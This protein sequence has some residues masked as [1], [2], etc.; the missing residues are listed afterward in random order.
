V[1]EALR[2][3]DRAYALVW[4]ENK[5]EQAIGGLEP[6]FEWIVPDHPDGAVRHGAEAVIDFWRDWRDQ[7]AGLDVSWELEEVGADR[8][9]LTF[10]MAGRGSVSGAPAEMHAV[11]LWTFRDG[12][13]VRMLMAESAQVAMVRE[14]THRYN[15]E[16]IDATLDFYTEDVVLEEDPDWPDGQVWHGREGVRAVFRERL[17]STSISVELEDAVERGNRVLTP[18]RWTAE[19][20]GSGAQTVLHAAAIWEFDGLLVNR[21]RFFLDTE[22]A[23]A[24][25]E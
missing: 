22:R 1:S 24:E 7:F 11:H 25:F 16:G 5:P 3:L 19:G 18:M 9:L 12:R 4:Q 17:D 15:R 14:G 6:D 13:Y 10:P 8:V 23:R 21:L 20:R 2:I